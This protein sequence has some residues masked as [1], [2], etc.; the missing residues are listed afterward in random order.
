MNWSQN[1]LQPAA[2][3]PCFRVYGLTCSAH[4]AKASPVAA[5]LVTAEF[6]NVRLHE[7]LAK[8]PPPN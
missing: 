7:C 1:A 5:Q 3:R 4:T 6:V 8:N 2:L